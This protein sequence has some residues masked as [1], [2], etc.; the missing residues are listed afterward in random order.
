[1]TDVL[2]SKANLYLKKLPLILLPFLLLQSEIQGQNYDAI[3]NVWEKSVL[4]EIYNENSILLSTGSG[5]LVG[6]KGEIAT[7]FHVIDVRGASYATA[8]FPEDEKTYY[9][10]SILQSDEI[11]DLAVLK[12]DSQT[13]PLVFADIG[14][15]AIG[16]KI[17]S[18]GSPQGLSGTV[19]DGIVS[20]KREIAGFEHMQITTPI[21]PGS[22]G[23]PVVNE[24]GEVIGVVVG[25]IISGQNLNFAIPIKHLKSLL[26]KVT[27]EVPFG[28]VIYVHNDGDSRKDLY[29]NFFPSSA[30]LDWSS[31]F[32]SLADAL[33]VA[34]KGNE[35]W[36]AEGIYKPDQGNDRTLGD[37]FSYYTLKDGVSIYGGFLGVETSREPLGDSN[38]TILSGKIDDNTSL[39][40]RNILA[41][42]LLSPL[43]VIDGLKVSHLNSDAN[44]TAQMVFI[45][46]SNLF[47]NITFSNNYSAGWG[48]V[49][50]LVECNSS[51]AGCSF[52]QNESN[53]SINSS[54][55]ITAIAGRNTF[56]DCH[57]ESNISPGTGA[58]LIGGNSSTAPLSEAH[59]INCVFKNNSALTGSGGALNLQKSSSSFTD[60]LFLNNTAGTEFDSGA[61][62]GIYLADSNSTLINC[63]FQGN[64]A[65]GEQ[66]SAFGNG[67]AV[68]SATSSL[69]FS[70]SLFVQNTANK[71]GGAIRNNGSSPKILNCTFSLN[72]AVE[73]GA[74]HSMGGSNPRIDNSILWG[75]FSTDNIFDQVDDNWTT[76]VP[77]SNIVEGWTDERAKSLSPS[78][79][80]TKNPKG[81]DGKWLTN[82]DGFLLTS[83]SKAIDAGTNSLLAVD[84][85]DLDNDKNFQESLPIDILGNPRIIGLSVDLGAYEYNPTLNETGQN[86][87]YTVNVSSSNGGSVSGGGNFEKGSTISIIAVAELGYVF[88]GWSGDG[89]G[90]P[91]QITITVDS[92]KSITANFAQDLND[93]DGDGLNNY[94]EL[95]THGTKVDDN[96]SDNDG[97]LDNEEIQ[98]GTDPNISN[99]DLVNF[100]NSKAITDQ[101]NARSAGQTT[102]IEMVKTNPSTYGLYSSEDMN[103]SIAKAKSEGE[104]S[105][106]SNPSAY[107]L[108]TKSSY[109]NALVA[110]AMAETARDYAKVSAKAEGI[111]EGKTIGETSVTSNPSAYNLVTQSAYDEMMNELMSASGADTTPYSEGW[112]YL[113][114]QGWLWT[115][116]TSYP[117]FY[118]STSKA[119]MYFQ[120]GNEKPRF[121]HYGSKEWMIL[122]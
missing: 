55:A 83:I 27:N 46:S 50:I 93:T 112:F 20:S 101:D 79:V 3:L 80:D 91:N 61:G 78:F 96:D 60:C 6:N 64:K 31:S 58:I 69:S 22:S 18:V 10:R 120:A 86:E 100:L 84:E 12:I 75:N 49:A 87:F 19:S 54:G 114:K 81:Q 41:G 39:W 24:K 74:I 13:A 38:K 42:E 113:P 118:D 68:Y 105:V 65:M 82:D 92:A 88:T 8:K 76:T 117:Y 90:K 57:F 34:K 40:S 23:G 98:V 29:N 36:V 4:I 25:S 47:R 9:I 95:V 103:A 21:S 52:I 110:L 51:F 26:G 122:E 15:F 106:T 2:Y 43:T 11:H 45:K 71:Y 109:D 77:H 108:V 7:N 1:M 32:S 17:F 94:A 99:T 102:G 67:G 53:R 37:R 70:N 85:F 104:T 62:G 115:N 44:N 5:F 59:F 89:I 33:A 73:G 116:R 48:G 66:G 35:I 63:I 28:K 16:Q 107:N 97:L 111:D 119:W 30:G 14:D 56:I 121:Y 72:Q